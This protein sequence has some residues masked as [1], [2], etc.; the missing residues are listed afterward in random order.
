MQIQSNQ[1]NAQTLKDQLICPVLLEPLSQAVCL[2]PCAHK[3]QEAA[4]KQLFGPTDGGWLVQTDVPCPLC[5]TSVLG[6]MTDH[7]TRNIVEQLFGLPESEIN[8]MLTQMKN[9]LAE[10]SISVE[11]DV[12]VEMP[13][14]GKPA[15]FVHENG[16]WRLYHTGGDL[17]RYMKFISITKDSLI[18]E[19]SI[20]GYKDGDVIISISYTNESFKEYLK[21]FDIFSD[22]PIMMYMSKNKDE[23]KI[24][25]NIL[26]D[27]N[28]I[29]DSHFKMIRDLVDKGTHS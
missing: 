8:A 18:K 3:V 20:L 26:A 28:E 19:F 22:I 14:P 1:F 11:K 29:P 21:Q 16:D 24:L 5:R 6:Y 2:V 7:S 13:Y 23:L 4:A 17:C 15:K 25:F 10:K 27:N 12:V 9:N